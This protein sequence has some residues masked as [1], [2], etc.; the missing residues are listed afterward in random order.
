MG[1]LMGTCRRTST[2]AW[3]FGLGTSMSRPERGL[4]IRVAQA[5]SSVDMAARLITPQ[6]LVIL[7]VGQV[8]AESA[9][10][11]VWW[12]VGSESNDGNCTGNVNEG[13][14][15]RNLYFCWSN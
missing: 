11:E 4:P 3:D 8:P 1:P 15:G 7:P 12:Q 6:A 13:R 5:S 9:V 10:K 14:G 2:R